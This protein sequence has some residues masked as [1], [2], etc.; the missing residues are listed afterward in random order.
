[1]G[2][3]APYDLKL[4][5]G[6][7]GVAGMPLNAAFKLQS[8]VLNLV[9]DYSRWL[10][11]GETLTGATLAM[12]PVTVPAIVA[13][14]GAIVSSNEGAPAAMAVFNV[15]AGLAGGTYAF[16]A[17]IT[18]S[19][20][21]TRTDT[22]YLNVAANANSAPAGGYPIG[23]PSGVA[24][25]PSCWIGEGQPWE[26]LGQPG[27]YFLDPYTQALYGPQAGGVWPAQASYGLPTWYAPNSVV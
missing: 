26:G 23:E 24:P 8:D 17:G 14:M 27:D 18:T 3:N 7:T 15:S 4:T 6:I 20:G 19:G 9:L 11:A 13:D 25:L 2:S 22:L 5:Y 21:R 1:M 10:A 12:T 16:A